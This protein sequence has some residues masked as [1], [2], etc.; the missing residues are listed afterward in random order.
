MTATSPVFSEELLLEM[1]AA[2]E[3]TLTPQE[4]EARVNAPWSAQE[5]AD[6]DELVRWFRRRYPTAGERLAAMRRRM[7]ALAALRGRRR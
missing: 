4:F 2:E 7:D 3:R 6:F 5:M 1:A